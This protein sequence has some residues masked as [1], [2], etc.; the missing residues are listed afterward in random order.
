MLSEIILPIATFGWC[1]AFA[2]FMFLF[3]IKKLARRATTYSPGEHAAKT[4]LIS[5]DTSIGVRDRLRSVVLY[6][7]VPIAMLGL[8]L[9]VDD[10]RFGAVTRAVMLICS[11]TRPGVQVPV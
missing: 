10:S 8:M 9:A 5:E 1:F 11:V 3:A 2:L 4:S 7:I 6:F